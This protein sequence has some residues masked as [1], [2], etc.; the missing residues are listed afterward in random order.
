MQTVANWMQNPKYVG[1]PKAIATTAFQ[2]AGTSIP[3]G[4][5]CQMLQQASFYATDFPKGTVIS[6]TGDV[7][8][9]YLPGI[10][11]AVK[12]PVEGGGEFYLAFNKKPATVEL[13]TYLSSP[14]WAETRIKAEGSDGGWTSA[15]NGVPLSDY[16]NPIDALSAKYLTAK[17]STFVFDASDAMP[18]AIGSGLEWTEFTNWFANGEPIK[19]VAANIDAGNWS[20]N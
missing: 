16:T 15:N 1:D 6:P 17:D 9:Y 7:W 8:A 18:A 3:S 20:T 11:P 14:Q 12:T 5:G 10:N 4:K 2:D 19:T 13:Q